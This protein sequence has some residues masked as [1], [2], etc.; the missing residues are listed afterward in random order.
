MTKNQNKSKQQKSENKNKEKSKNSKKR[1]W[2]ILFLVVFALAVTV[3]FAARKNIG[4]RSSVGGSTFAVRRDNLVVTVQVGGSIRAHKSIQYKCQV[5]RGRDIGE[6]SI[7]SIVQPGTYVTQEDVDNGMVLVQLDSSALEDRIVQERIELASDQENAVAAKEAYDIQLIE[8]ESSIAQSELNVRFA[9]LDLQKYLGAE[10]AEELTKDINEAVVNLSAFIAPFVKEVEKDP[11]ILAG[12]KSWQ[13]MKD[14]QDQIILAEG[15]LKQAEDTY[16]GTLKLHDANYVSDLELEGDRLS[17]VNR[18]FRAQNSGVNLD[19]FVRYDFPKNA[20]Q[21]LSNYIEAQRNLQRTYAQCRSREAQAKVR[22]NFAEQRLQEQV[23]QVK[24]LGQQIAYC[25]IKAK[26]PGLVVYGTGGEADIF[27]SMRGRGGGGMSSGIIAE[28]ETVTEG[29]TLISMPDTAAMVAEIGVHETEVDKVRAGQ[30]ASIVMDAFPDQRLTGKVIEVA[31][32]P[33]QQRGW[34]NPDLKVYK[35]LV[36]I[37]GTHDFLRSRMSCKVEILVERLDD[38]NIVP[39]TVVANRGGRKVCYVV[40]QQGAQ[41]ERVVRT[42]VFN[43]TFVQI[44]DGLEV[45][46]KVMLNPPLITETAT[47]VDVFEGV[48]TLP[49]ELGQS[50]NINA[51]GMES[52]IPSSGQT[53]RGAGRSGGNRRGGRRGTEGMTEEQMMKLKEFGEKMR[54]GEGLTEEQIKQ[55]K[56]QYGGQRGGGEGP[57]EEQRK[58]FMERLGGR[59]GRRDTEGENRSEQ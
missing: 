16:T 40:N 57:T 14:F 15:E 28:G 33:D 55:L 6:V 9:L 30:P 22:L 56:E 50:D 12:T 38:V 54:S 59:R 58:Q 46:E 3:L 45:A 2:M 10:L 41:E 18:Q 20:E 49:Q 21:Y 47:T 35:T 32:L 34:M 17:V 5:E 23:D 36:S 52:Q 39:I 11:N 24:N 53:R 19:L 31:P 37:D 13:E 7:L 44:I 1:L 51:G 43:D 4:P 25:T 42:G 48:Q 8:N 26:A 29:Q 27:R